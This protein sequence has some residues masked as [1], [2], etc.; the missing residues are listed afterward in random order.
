MDQEFEA[1][2]FICRNLRKLCPRLVPSTLWG[3]SISRIA[4][5]APEVGLI[6][7]DECIEVFREIRKF[8]YSLTRNTLCEICGEISSEIDE[9]WHYYVSSSSGELVSLL[10]L[11][12]MPRN[13]LDELLPSLRG[14]AYLNN[15][16]FVC[17]KCHFAKHQGL[18]LVKGVFRE[19]VSQLARVNNINVSEAA[20]LISIAFE[21]HRLLS[22][23]D[24]WEFRISEIRG[25]SR[26]LRS[27]IERV[28]NFM[29]QK[30]LY[31]E[32]SWIFY[33]KPQLAYISELRALR[34][35]I[36]LLRVVYEK[37]SVLKTSD[38]VWLNTL[39]EVIR[40][41]L[42]PSEVIVL[43]NEFKYYMSLLLEEHTVKFERIV[44]FI[45][46][47]DLEKAL[48]SLL[49]DYSY[50][51]GKWMLFTKA[52]SA[53]R[54]F[55]E[56]INIL[57]ERKLAYQAKITSVPSEYKNNSRTPIIIYTPSTLAPR[58]LVEI[59]QVLLEIRD[60]YKLLENLYFK[61]D[62]FTKKNIYSRSS[63]IKPYIYLRY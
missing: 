33:Y 20:K 27:K 24:N 48:I 6:I 63:K 51:T 1:Y 7:C 23:I 13:E 22:R 3:L 34:E 39:L 42:E 56:I 38:P 14:I 25:I 54:L 28:L 55:R 32:D 16:V 18:A 52:N 44:K 4:H 21:I 53:P 45:A 35:T 8:W 49:Y 2:H 31:S 62:L 29:F 41:E 5:L 59:L 60:K 10:S 9:E 43:V 40:E 36:E 47:G 15:F 50:L 17:E 58:H 11:L 46:Q 30:G 12:E 61:P 37:S 57:E 26:E 19:A